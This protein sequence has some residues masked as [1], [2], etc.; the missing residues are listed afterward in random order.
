M[1]PSMSKDFPSKRNEASQKD[2]VHFQVADHGHGVGNDSSVSQAHSWRQGQP[3]PS[4]GKFSED[5]VH[6]HELAEGEQNAPFLLLQ[7]MRPLAIELVIQRCPG[8]WDSP[9][10]VTVLSRNNTKHW[11]C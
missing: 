6:S 7:A 2:I 5:Q 8:L 9:L 4:S 10:G 1:S 11:N 3:G